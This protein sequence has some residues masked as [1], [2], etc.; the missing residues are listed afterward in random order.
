MDNIID[1]LA[2]DLQP[3]RKHALHRLLMLSLMPGIA[4]S[5]AFILL[6]HGFRPDIAAAVSQAAFWAKSAYPLLLSIVGVVALIKVARPG[7]RPV[8]AAAPVLVIYALLIILGLLQLNAATSAYEHHRLIMGISYWFCPLIILAAGAPLMAATFWFLR[9]AAPTQPRLAGFIAG[10][11]AGS[12]GA[13]VYS[14]GC[15]ENGL[16]FVALWY[17]LG[18]VLCGLIGMLLGRQL[19]RW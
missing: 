2:K 14:W 10:A 4:F 18:I 11:T 19:L 17:T 12:I 5:A 6:G 8:A 7:G 13:W 16:T 9:R 15:I 3:V 1:E